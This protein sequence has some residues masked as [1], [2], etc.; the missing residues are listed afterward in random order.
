MNYADSVN[1]MDY[2]TLKHVSNYYYFYNSKS[3]YL[4]QAYDG[5]SAFK[6][7][8]NL[9]KLTA[10]GE[11]YDVLIHK[12]TLIVLQSEQLCLLTLKGDIINT[13]TLV[14]DTNSIYYYGRFS[15]GYPICY[16]GSN[17]NVYMQRYNIETGFSYGKG[18]NSS[19][20]AYFNIF[21]AYSDTLPIYPSPCYKYNLGDMF[22]PNRI[23]TGNNLIYSYPPDANLYIYNSHNGKMKVAG[24]KSLNQKKSIESFAQSDTVILNFKDQLELLTTLPQ[25]TS[26]QTSDSGYLY[27]MFLQEIEYK[28]KSGLFNTFRDKKCFLMKIDSTFTVVAEQEIPNKYL[29]SKMLQV[30]KGVGIVSKVNPISIDFDIYE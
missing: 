18:L 23:L 8:T 15:D 4:E 13:W 7:A 9:S 27:R 30:G 11:V 25:Y 1:E 10:G 16:S 6:A 26:I 20:E 5:D 3:G 17:G 24:C 29:T 19:L 22:H 12:D 2:L 28:N 14:T 21:S